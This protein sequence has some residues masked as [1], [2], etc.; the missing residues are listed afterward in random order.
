MLPLREG[1]VSRIRLKV[2]ERERT[3]LAVAPEPLALPA[4]TR[5][6]VLRID[7]SGKAQIAPEDSIF[8]SEE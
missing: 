8:G 5:V 7:E 2:Q 4:G 1:G 6:V 3:M